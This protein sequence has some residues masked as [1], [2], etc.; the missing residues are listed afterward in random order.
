MTTP[1]LDSAGAQH[2]LFSSANH[3]ATAFAIT[4]NAASDI[5]LIIGAEPP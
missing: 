2:S 3:N 5:V 1:V 4:C